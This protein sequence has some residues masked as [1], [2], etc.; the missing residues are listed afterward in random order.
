MR[1]PGRRLFPLAL[2]VLALAGCKEKPPSVLEGSGVPATEARDVP[3]FTR[4]SVGSHIQAHVTV[5][6]ASKLEFRADKNLLPHVVSRVTNGTLS[7]DTDDRVKPTIP[8][9]VTLSVPRLDSV[10]ATKGGKIVVEGL[11]AETFEARVSDGAAIRASGSAQTLVVHGAGAGTFD[12]QKLPAQSATVRLEYAARAELGYL[13][14]LDVQLKGM[15]R[16]TYGGSPE[17]KQDIK[18]KARL[19]SRDVR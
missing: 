11:K 5:G 4:L 16:V 6:E 10:S 2:A 17:I 8:L 9:T 15:T 13:E 14:K 19:V 1:I 12:F 7:L 3:P 18:E